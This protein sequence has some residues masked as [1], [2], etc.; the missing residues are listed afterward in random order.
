MDF[1]ALSD[2]Q[3]LAIATP[4]MDNL[5]D[6]S[7]RID[8]KAHVRD[9]SRRLKHIVTESYLQQ[10]CASYQQEKGVFKTREYMAVFKRE[11]SVVVVWRQTFT[12]AKGSY[13]AEMVL[14]EEDGQIVCDHVQVL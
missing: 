2:E 3:V 5:M 6:A 8:H 11:H 1:L 13:L 10:V 9:F 14:L 4:I 7:T 12:K